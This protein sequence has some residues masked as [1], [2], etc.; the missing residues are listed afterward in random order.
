LDFNPERKYIVKEYIHGVVASQLISED[1]VN[2]AILE[3]L[4]KM[5]RLA[6][7]GSLNIDYFPTNFVWQD[8]RLFYI[9]YEC[10]PY[11][12]EWDLLNWGIYYWANSNGF[13]DYLSTGDIKFINESP[14][15]GIPLKI[16]FEEKILTWLKKYDKISSSQN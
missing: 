10:N 9:D 14:E 1:K 13:K 16:Q 11:K 15:T 7:K 12:P 4:F 2:D 5:Y 6:K 8:N 3:Q